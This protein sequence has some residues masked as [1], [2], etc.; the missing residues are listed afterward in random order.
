MKYIDNYGSVLI[1]IKFD[2]IIFLVC[3]DRVE[4]FF[5]IKIE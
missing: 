2:F 1:V 3:I 4:K 5:I